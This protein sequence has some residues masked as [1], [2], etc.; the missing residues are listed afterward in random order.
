M[1]IEAPH[2]KFSTVGKACRDCHK[3]R[4]DWEFQ[5]EIRGSGAATGG[6]VDSYERDFED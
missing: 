5:G 4:E 3:H 6:M 1:K 2:K